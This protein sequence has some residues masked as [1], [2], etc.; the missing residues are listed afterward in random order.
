[1]NANR[2][3]STYLLA[4][5][6]VSTSL[7]ACGD[8]KNVLPDGRVVGTS[9]ARANDAAASDSRLTHATTD[10]TT[11]ATTDA[12][13]HATTHATT[14]ATTDATTHATTDATIVGNPDASETALDARLDAPP[15]TIDAAAPTVDANLC[16]N[17]TLDPGEQCDDGNHDN[18]DACSNQCITLSPFSWSQAAPQNVPPTQTFS[19]LAYDAVL[20]RTVMFS[21]SSIGSQTPS[22]TW[23]WD[24]AD[25]TE[26][27]P[28]HSPSARFGHHMTYD[29]KRGVVVLFGGSDNMTQASL[30]DTW[31]WDGTDWT[32]QT[33]LTVPPERANHAISFDA[34][35][36]T[37][38]MFGG[39][40]SQKNAPLGDMWSW[41]G[42]D[43]TEL[44]PTDLPTA[45][46][47]MAMA[48]DSDRQRIVLFSGTPMSGSSQNDF[49][50]W[51]GTD[52]SEVTASVGP[53]VG[54]FNNGMSMAYDPSHK[55]MVVL[56]G[57]ETNDSTW[58]WDGATLTDLAPASLAPGVQHYG[59]AYDPARDNF[60][61]FGG[62]VFM[63][64]SGNSQTWIYSPS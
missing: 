16:G 6:W 8:G 33:P 24:G 64:L 54:F 35:S 15:T 63:A 10:A 38:V 43:W 59:F 1:M 60:V 26:V 41:D 9:D 51:N 5:L 22:Q 3:T 23:Q 46:Y 52:W 14:D 50:E 28:M 45:R 62:L 31:T 34:A 21:G 36:G 7:L 39:Y 44:T 11:H 4:T 32:E 12:T 49:W 55:R 40:S 42:S 17:G 56:I 61:L 53:S 13:T 30:S 18:T 20:D 2:K 47:D 57:G 37:V 19:A 29:S 48:Y 25:W 58:Q 27:F